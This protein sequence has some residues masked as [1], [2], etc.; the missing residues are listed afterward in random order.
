MTTL[1][2]PSESPN[3]SSTCAIPKSHGTVLSEKVSKRIEHAWCERDEWVVDLA[4]PV[5][6]RIIEQ[7][8]YYWSFAN[9][10][11]KISLGPSN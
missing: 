4:M 7:E 6:A 11:F 10:C 5:G 8:L 9:L 2:K 1:K 3:K